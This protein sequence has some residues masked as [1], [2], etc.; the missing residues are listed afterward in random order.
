[1][2]SQGGGWSRAAKGSTQRWEG[3]KG[4]A[5]QLWEQHH[6]K[7]WQTG[8]EL[9]QSK[10]KMNMRKRAWQDRRHQFPHIG[11][12][13]FGMKGGE[14]KH[15]VWMRG[16]TAVYDCITCFCAFVCAWQLTIGSYHAVHSEVVVLRLQ[17]HSMLVVPSDLCVTGQEKPLVV[18]YPI[19]H[20]QRVGGENTVSF[21]K[22]TSNEKLPILW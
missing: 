11:R 20:L 15:L 22:S 8:A 21:T 17:L 9:K 1:M 19:K 6:D 5:G 16:M 13:W 10:K 2:M 7:T 4:N 12:G 14:K 3:H 18:H